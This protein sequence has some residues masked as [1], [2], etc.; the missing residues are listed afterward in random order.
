M[1]SQLGNVPG[2]FG[3]NTISYGNR[4]VSHMVYLGADSMSELSNALKNVRSTSDFAEFAS[5]VKDIRVSVNSELV[6]YVT[7]F[8]GE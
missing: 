4:Y 5:S 7:S 3:L 1:N 8:N 2:S 6:Q